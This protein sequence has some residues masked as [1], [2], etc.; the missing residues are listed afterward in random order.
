MFVRSLDGDRKSQ[1][2]KSDS[3]EILLRVSSYRR[4]I[5]ETVDAR[6][7]VFGFVLGG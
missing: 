5:A 2:I 1:S 4:A 3:R 6:G 7:S